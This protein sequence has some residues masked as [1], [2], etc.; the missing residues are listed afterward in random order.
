[1][2]LSEWFEYQLRSTLDG[3]MWAVDQVPK[4]RL[5]LPAPDHLGGWATIQHVVHTL[6]YEQRYALPS[7]T[8]WLGVPP[9]IPEES[10]RKPEPNPPVLEEKL[11]QFKKVRLAEINMVTKFNQNDWK[12]VRKTTFWGEVSLYW[13]VGKTYQHTLEHTNNILGIALFWDTKIKHG[14]H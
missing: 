13:L 14:S 12:K 3:F 2:N 6:D 1:M 9:V 5:Y 8:Q 7:M 4:E 10:E 11:H